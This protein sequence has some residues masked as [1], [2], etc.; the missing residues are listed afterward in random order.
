MCQGPQSEVVKGADS[1][2]GNLNR[3]CKLS[4]YNCRL[5]SLLVSETLAKKEYIQSSLK[6]GI[7]QHSS[8]PAG[9]GFFFV[10]KKDGTLQPCIDHRELNL[11]DILIF[12]QSHLSPESCPTSFATPSST[13]LILEG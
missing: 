9:A 6:A 13:P 1:G 10:G 8:S 2:E 11:D 4:C 5:Y 3:R 7:I 12:P